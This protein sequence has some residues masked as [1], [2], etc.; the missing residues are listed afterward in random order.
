MKIYVFVG[1]GVRVISKVGS[2]LRSVCPFLSSPIRV[3]TRVPGPPAEHP[4]PPALVHAPF[5]SCHADSCRRGP[6]SVIQAV[7]FLRKRVTHACITNTQISICCNVYIHYKIGNYKAGI[8]IYKPI[9]RDCE[10]IHSVKGQS[11]QHAHT[12]LVL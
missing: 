11:A 7:S 10:S 3:R 4:L 8:S 12:L 2:F 5:P 9:L 6:C 1:F